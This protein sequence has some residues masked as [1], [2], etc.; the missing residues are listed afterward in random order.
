MTGWRIGY[1]VGPKQMIDAMVIVQSQICSGA[2]SVAQ[3]A[4]LAALEG[5]QDCR[6]IFRLAY[7][8][9]RDLVINA[10]EGIE[11]LEL[12]PPRGAFYALIDCTR[13]MGNKIG[14]DPEF[15][16]RLLDEVGVAAVPGSVYEMP[17]YFRIST[18]TDNATLSAAME[19]IKSCVQSI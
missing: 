2:C 12:L 8:S 3:A 13:A 7:A 5:P 17:G 1:G 14:S 16:E 4:A 19:R 10:I 18:A 9:R 11:A 15:V 6:G